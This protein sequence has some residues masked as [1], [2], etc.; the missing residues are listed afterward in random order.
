VLP[1]RYQARFCLNRRAQTKSPPCVPNRF[2]AQK[3]QHTAKQRWSRHA[4]QMRCPTSNVSLPFLLSRSCLACSSKCNRL[5]FL[6]SRERSI[7]ELACKY[8]R[9]SARHTGNLCTLYRL[10]D[11]IRYTPPAPCALAAIRPCASVLRY[12]STPT[13]RW[14]LHQ[15]PLPVQ[16]RPPRTGPRTQPSP[17]PLS[18]YHMQYRRRPRVLATT[19]IANVPEEGVVRGR[20]RRT[21][22]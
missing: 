14:L 13:S 5:P 3:R 9:T 11:V 1:E 10:W 12:I 6:F 2:D 22:S 21:I 15:Q 19:A 17:T 20:S 18:L 7:V 4:Y 16:T 8:I